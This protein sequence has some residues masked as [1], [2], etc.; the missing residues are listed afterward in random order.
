MT[1]DETL[2][3]LATLIAKHGDW[4]AAVNA[5]RAVVGSN[6][7]VPI[8][9]GDREAVVNLIRAAVGSDNAALARLQTHI[10]T[11]DYWGQ[12][13]YSLRKPKGIPGAD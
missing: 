1:H 3:D 5:F 11:D 8:P 10:G 13:K 7:A 2:Q 6:S 12:H 4:E 9:N